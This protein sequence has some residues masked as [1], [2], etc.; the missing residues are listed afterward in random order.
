MVAFLKPN[1]KFSTYVQIGVTHT[2]KNTQ[3][4]TLKHTPTLT[5]ICRNMKKNLC[6]S[7]CHEELLVKV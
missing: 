2:T 5:Q 4:R 7:L 6:I 1:K 3:T